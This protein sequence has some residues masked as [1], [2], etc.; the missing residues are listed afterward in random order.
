MN[1]VKKL[2]LHNVIIK[3]D[4]KSRNEIQSVVVN[5]LVDKL[6][7][8]EN[9]LYQQIIRSTLQ[10]S[11]FNKYFEKWQTSSRKDVRFRKDNIDWL[12]GEIKLN[13]ENQASTLGKFE[14]FYNYLLQSNCVIYLIKIESVY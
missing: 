2:D 9:D 11:F 13:F 5:Y 3:S 12:N 1:T 8:S 10:S 6:D 7:C 14:N 4:K